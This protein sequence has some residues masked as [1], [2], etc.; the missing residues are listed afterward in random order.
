MSS[1]RSW[2]DFK[3]PSWASW[4]SSSSGSVAFAKNSLTA[5]GLEQAGADGLVYEESRGIL[6]GWLE[7]VMRHLNLD[8]LPWEVPAAMAVCCAV[9][10]AP[11]FR[12]N[13][14][15]SPDLPAR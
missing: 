7:S 2:H 6:K 5:K 8:G 12:A 3:R 4:G 9:S 13:E 15:M 14:S 11:A 10:N 1:Q